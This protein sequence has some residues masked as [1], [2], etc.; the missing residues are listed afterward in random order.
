MARRK[1]EGM[2]QATLQEEERHI[3]LQHEA[4]MQA[5]T[6]EQREKEAA[7]L[8]RLRRPA[9]TPDP[10]SAWERVQWSPWTESPARSGVS[11]RNNASPPGGVIVV[12]TYD[13]EDSDDEDF[14]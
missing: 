9:S 7:R 1:E 12:D 6:A 13:Q 10:R 2:R 14:Y 3:H 5:A 8:A 11:S 4:D